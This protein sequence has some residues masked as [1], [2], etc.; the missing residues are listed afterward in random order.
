MRSVAFVSVCLS[1]SSLNF[2]RLDLETLLLVRRPVHLIQG[3][4]VKIK[5]TR[6]KRVSVCPVL[7]LTFEY[8]DL[9]T[10]FYYAC[11]Q[12]RVSRSWGQGQGHRSVTN[13]HIRGW[14]AF[15]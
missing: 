6:A 9:Q 14:C 1:C 13:T 15:D 11:S 7:A 5:V 10:S 2:Q 12:G 8:I 4:Q 3:H